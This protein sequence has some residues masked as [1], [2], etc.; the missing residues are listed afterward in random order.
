MN[1]KSISR[2]GIESIRFGNGGG[3]TGAVTAYILSANGQLNKVEG[4]K[5]VL[6]KT[7][8]NK[9]VK[10]FFEKASELKNYQFNEPENVYSFLEIQTKENKQNITWG[11]GSTKIDSRVKKLYDKLMLLT[12]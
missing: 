2:T 12:K 11:F 7:V 5:N 9:M 8:D 6:I 10:D 1:T 3:F 4:N